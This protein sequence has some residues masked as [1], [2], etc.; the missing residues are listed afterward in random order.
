MDFYRW[1]EHSRRCTRGFLQFLFIKSFFSN[2]E[3]MLY[4]TVVIALLPSVQWW[5]GSMGVPIQ[6][7][8]GSGAIRFDTL[9]SNEAGVVNNDQFQ[10]S[11]TVKNRIFFVLLWQHLVTYWM[12]VLVPNSNWSDSNMSP[13]GRSIMNAFCWNRKQREAFFE[14]HCEQKRWEFVWNL[15]IHV[16]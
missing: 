7:W 16:F 10:S 13:I 11:R 6:D 1:F 4:A 9:R 14:I 3:T 2:R 8:V 15:T 12:G 5:M